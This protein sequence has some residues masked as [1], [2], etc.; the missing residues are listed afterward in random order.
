[1]PDQT[2]LRLR[3]QLEMPTNPQVFHPK[4]PAR[5]RRCDHQLVA[6]CARNSLIH[7]P[8]LKFQR[9]L[10]ADGLKT[11]ARTPV[12]QRDVSANRVCVK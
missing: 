12:A 11:V 2:A 6:A 7:E 8:I 4:N 3:G 10:H 5:L 9:R 1:M